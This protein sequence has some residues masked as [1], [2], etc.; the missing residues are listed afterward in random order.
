MTAT[1]RS[2]RSESKLGSRL[3]SPR[4]RLPYIRTE[5]E[6]NSLLSRCYALGCTCCVLIATSV[7]LDAIVEFGIKSGLIKI[8]ADAA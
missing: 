5:F 6:L 2:G 8:Q 1:V 7:D 3:R 4:G